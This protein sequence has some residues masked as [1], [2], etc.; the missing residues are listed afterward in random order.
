MI[1]IVGST[2]PTWENKFK[3]SKLKLK[4]FLASES[5]SPPQLGAQDFIVEFSAAT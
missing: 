4:K 5:A 1:F 3:K 2:S